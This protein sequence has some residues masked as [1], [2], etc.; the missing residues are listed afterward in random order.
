MDEL[1]RDHRHDHQSTTTISMHGSEHPCQ[2][3]YLIL[4]GISCHTPQD[5]WL[6]IVDTL[7]QDVCVLT[8]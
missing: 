7:P 2:P 5:A 8:A 1:R 6:L 3:K 4:H